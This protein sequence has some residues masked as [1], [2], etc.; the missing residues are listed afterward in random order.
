MGQTLKSLHS[1]LLLAI[2]VLFGTP[3][4]RAQDD[5]L[6]SA[7]SDEP[8]V[9]PPVEAVAL[10]PAFHIDVPLDL[11]NLHQAIDRVRIRCDVMGPVGGDPHIA[12]GVL[13]VPVG[14]DGSV[15]GTYRVFAFLDPDE[16]GAGA[17]RYRCY[18]TLHHTQGYDSDDANH[19]DYVIPHQSAA[20]GDQH[21]Y[22]SADPNEEFVGQVFGDMP[23]AT[24]P[25][26]SGSQDASN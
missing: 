10:A 15:N 22:H 12:M 18:M 19:D 4:A 11:R 2:I 26:T 3:N 9:I 5:A 24:T 6:S 17:D 25:P 8:E 23:E 1:I 13:D 20:T 16:S 14:V 21:D 7:S